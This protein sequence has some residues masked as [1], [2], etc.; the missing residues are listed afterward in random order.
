[1][2]GVFIVAVV[3]VAPMNIPWSLAVLVLFD[4]GDIFIVNDYRCWMSI[5]GRSGGAV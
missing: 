5:C 4:N 1:M 3:V 2:I